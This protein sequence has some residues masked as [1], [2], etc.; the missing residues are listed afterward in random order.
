M[1][2][3]E[4]KIEIVV[5]QGMFGAWDGDEPIDTLIRQIA[6]ACP[7]EKIDW[8]EKYGARFEN[9]T[10]LMRP[11]CWCDEDE[12]LWCGG[13]VCPTKVYLYFKDG[14]R[15]TKEQHDAE[16]HDYVGSLADDIYEYGTKA[17]RD[18]RKKWEAKIKERN[19][20][21]TIEFA[22][23]CAYC[24]STGLWSHP[25]LVKSF[26]MPNF[27]HKP[28]GF[29]VRWY[30]YISRDM[31]FYGSTDIAGLKAMTEDCIRSINA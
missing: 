25:G 10:F 23:N 31:E 11:Y 27:W 17:Y 12:C 1:V 13:C 9:D 14:V 5:P 16:W 7:S 20:R 15:I 28:S 2:E 24:T 3:D 21:Y 4:Q 22:G 29:R 19:R 26:G 30:K 18:Y 8:A 6:L